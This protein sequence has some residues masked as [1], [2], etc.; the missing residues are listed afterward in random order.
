MADIFSKKKRSEIMSKI[1]NKDSK[2]EIEFR[3]ALWKE[4]F[5]YRK[6]VNVYF[7]K[8]DLILKKY[9]TVIFIDSCFWHGCKKH[10]KMPATNKK[11]WGNK[12]ERNKERDKEIK[13]YYKKIGWNIIRV[14][15]HDINKNLDKIIIKVSK[16]LNS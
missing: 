4:G 5:R 1:K 13:R 6:N 11:F 15:E 14:W 7:G 2:I 8:P 12:I 16:I 3:K 10:C 9:K